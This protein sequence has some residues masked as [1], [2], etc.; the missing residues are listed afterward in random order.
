MLFNILE[1]FLAQE[2]SC[3]RFLADQSFQFQIGKMGGQPADG[4]C[5]LNQ[6]FIEAK[7]S[8]CLFEKADQGFFIRTQLRE[9]IQLLLALRLHIQQHV[10]VL[11]VGDQGSAVFDQMI[12]TSSIEVIDIPWQSADIPVLFDGVFRGQ[13]CAA[14]DGAFH[15]KDSIGKSADDAVTGRKIPSFGFGARFV[16]AYQSPLIDN[17]PGQFQILRRVDVFPLQRPELLSSDELSSATM[18][19][20]V[21]AIAEACNR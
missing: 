16:F 4:E 13:K 11:R 14:G 6:Q 17:A 9:Y 15:H 8:L 19:E 3:F 7:S 12:R 20:S 1:G 2:K 18:G 21:D 5:T 10:E